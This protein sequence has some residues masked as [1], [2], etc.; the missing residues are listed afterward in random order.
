MSAGVKSPVDCRASCSS[1]HHPKGVY[2]REMFE[3]PGQDMRYA[4]NGLTGP[5]ITL[6]RMPAG[7]GSATCFAAMKSGA[8][9]K[10]VLSLVLSWR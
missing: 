10:V 4:A 2:G 6:H 1:D 5:V 3:K 9:A 8:A 7:A